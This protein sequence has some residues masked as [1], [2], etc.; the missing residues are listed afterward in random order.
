MTRQLAYLGLGGNLG[1]PIQ[2]IIDARREILAWEHCS[3]GRC[4]YF[5]RSSPV[6]YANQADFINCVLQIDTTAQ[7]LYLLDFC[8]QLELSLGRLRDPKNKNAARTIDIDILMMGD[9]QYSDDRL[10]LPHPR[11]NERLFVL[12]PLLDLLDAKQQNELSKKI[13]NS[14]FGD[15]K[16]H[17]LVL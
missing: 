13:E 15:Q 9:L 10:E 1:D 2:Q 12:L 14:D 11:M 7:P 16:V 6:G 8:Q 5:Y 17:R 3:M 4:S